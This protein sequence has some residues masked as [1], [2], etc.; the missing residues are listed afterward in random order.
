MTVGDR[1]S[2]EAVARLGELVDHAG[3]AIVEFD[4][5]GSGVHVNDWWR[6]LTGVTDPVP[7]DRVRLYELTH[8]A[9]R[10]AMLA[11]WR[12][13]IESAEPYNSLT[14]LL[15]P[16]GSYRTLQART[17][18]LVSPDGQV[19]GFVTALI[20]LS[21]S[22][23]L[24]EVATSVPA[25][26]L[27]SRRVGHVV[28]GLDGL[29]RAVNEGFA[30]LVQASPGDI[31][32]APLVD[33][34]DPRDRQRL[35]TAWRT[36]ADGGDFVEDEVRFRRPDGTTV[37]A[38]GGASPVWDAA[39][40]LIGYQA[41]TFDVTERRRVLEALAES[42]ERHR[43]VVDS[44][45]E[46]VLI[47]DPS[48]RLE[49]LNPSAWSILGVEEVDLGRSPSGRMDRLARLR[50]VDEH[51]QPLQLDQLPTAETLRSGRA[52]SDIVLGVESPQG[53]TQWLS[54]DIHPYQ[55][56]DGRFGAV[57]SLRDITEH[58]QAVDAL[59]ESEAQ[60][61]ALVQHAPIGQLLA[62]MEG[63]VLQ[64]NEAYAEI[65]GV[66]PAD[67]S[68]ERP[69]H[70]IHA[71]DLHPLG[72]G[73]EA[74]LAG[75]TDSFQAEYRAIR[76]DGSTL[77]VRGPISLLRD[78]TGRPSHI[79]AFVE[80]VDERRAAQ[81]WADS[82]ARIVESTS[83]IVGTVDPRS[84]RLRYLN[85]AAREH[86]GHAG[87][88][89]ADVDVRSLFTAEAAR[90][91]EADIAVAVEMGRT[92]QGELDMLQADRQLIHVL[93][94]VSADHDDRGAIRQISFVGR[95][96]T[97][98]RRHERELAH[99][100][101]HDP[102][103]NLPNRSLLLQLIDHALHRQDRTVG[104]TAL[105]FLDLDRF[106]TVNDTLGHEVGDALLVE[107]AG[108]IQGV[109]RPSDTV[110]RLGGDEFVVLCEEVRDEHQAVTLTQR[111]TSALESHPF[112][113]AGNRI[114]VTAS[115][116]IAL[117][118]DLRAH[119]EA[120]LR[121]ADAAMYRA[122]D[123]GRARHEIFDDDMR[124]RTIRRLELADDLE[125]AVEH[126]EI[127]VY[128][129]PIVNLTTGRVEGV[130][131]LARWNHPTRGMLPPSAFIAL[132]EE[133]GLIVGLGLS[134]LS[135]ACDQARRWQV[136]LGTRAPKVHV[137]LSARQLSSSN[138]PR[139]VKGVLDQSLIEADRLCLEVTESVLMEDAPSSVTVLEELKAIGVELAIDDFGTGYSSLAYLGRFP[140]DVL[141]V[142]RSF[143]EGLDSRP[144]GTEIA[145]VVLS[146]ARSLGLSCVAEGVE[147]PEQLA[148]LRALGCET[149]QGFFF[150]RPLPIPELDRYLTRVY[151]VDGSIDL[152]NPDA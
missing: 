30:G 45:H 42:E 103:T 100:A 58:K 71:E 41:V 138:L 111:M 77:W 145:A 68:G 108:R 53:V 107:V 139:L 96:V 3:V 137:N 105:L 142:D 118:T 57:V 151:P 133:T 114:R 79:H 140:V 122:K 91:W 123:R 119:P 44:L 48:G 85:R 67:L 92:W 125:R 129:Q 72:Q 83:D 89:L 32:A 131:A 88:D 26:A 16:E 78:E 55:R 62:D 97:D 80:D 43:V 13:A 116:G 99:Q 93:V 148:G 144:D 6:H 113:I 121:D 120:L 98:Q 14:R 81:E 52:F 76:A 69:W 115:V 130:E 101:T 20:D 136:E 135:R 128:Y 39:G 15:R 124:R 104:L 149:A 7:I 38:L 59:R 75:E 50:F 86:L 117:G 8:P 34:V 19:T 112:D 141:K 109:L 94:S 11:A 106:K 23:A 31:E 21:R 66:P 2:P 49:A 95:D 150:A 60:Y 56:P 10:E 5:D 54:M 74:L 9:D 127:A 46:G 35:V 27:S 25:G 51:H 146:L 33:L 18:P 70:R 12:T 73:L 24:D 61:R 134:V 64:C 4:V 37:W 90:L 102:L 17:Q 22:V 126:S 132:A 82:L 143:V 36:L 28:V 29:I 40:A 110:A 1:L 63:R 84:S 147:T 47:L 152:R 65:I 87:R